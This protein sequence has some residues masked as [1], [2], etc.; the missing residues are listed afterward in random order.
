MM[1]DKNDQQSTSPEDQHRS[2]FII[3]HSSFI[4][5]ATQVARRP[6]A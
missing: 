5:S 3:H 1:N 4:I 2:T 6:T